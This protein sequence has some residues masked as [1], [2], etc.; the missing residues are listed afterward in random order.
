[1][2]T[3]KMTFTID[4]ETAAE[5]ERTA[6]TLR[7]PK[8]EVVRDAIRDYAERAGQLSEAERIRRLRAIEE[9]AAMPPTRSQADVG[10]ELAE[11][12]WARRHAGRA[13]SIE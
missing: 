13:T 1:M 9:F 2:A 10:R 6:E 11:I 7:K 5:L 12:R 8:S 3:I 4:Q